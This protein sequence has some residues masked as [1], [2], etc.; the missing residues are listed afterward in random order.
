MNQL[1]LLSPLWLLLAAS[2]GYLIGR[3]RSGL[4]PYPVAA[5][6]VLLCIGFLGLSGQPEQLP[7]SYAAS[8]AHSFG[9]EYR[10]RIDGLALTFAVLITGI[11]ALVFLYAASYMKEK[12]ETGGFFLTLAVFTAAMLGLVL[13]DN[14]L[15]TFLFWELTSLC[16]FLLISFHFRKPEVAASA[17]KAL[18]VTF[19]G[20]LVLL[21]GVILISIAGVR[22]GATLV[23][24]LT[25]SLIS[26]E[27][28]TGPLYPWI[29]ACIAV[30]VA[31]KSAQFPFH[32]WLPAAMAGPTPVSSFLHSATMVKA[33]VFL[34]AR[35][36]PV[37]GGT[38]LWSIVFCS[39]GVTTMLLGALLAASF[40]D[41]KKI[42]AFST[43]AVL[44]I[45][46]MLLGIGTPMAVKAAVVFLVAHALYKASLFQI[47]GNLDKA[48][49]SRDIKELS[50]LGR[51]LPLTAVAALLSSFSKAGSPPL[52]GFFGKELAYAAKLELGWS[53][54]IMM[55]AAVFANV[56][57]VGLAVSIAFRPFWKG[58]FAKTSSPKDIQKLP[59]VMT[60]C[61][62]LLGF[63]GLA[64]GVFPAMFDRTLGSMMVSAVLGTQTEMKLK[65][66]HGFNP[67]SLIVIGLSAVTL[68]AGVAV[69]FKLRPVIIKGEALRERLRFGPD[70][71]YDW[72]MQSIASGANRLTAWLQSGDLVS[73]C[74]WV[75]LS[76]FGLIALALFSGRLGGKWPD[77]QWTE[78]VT[79][80]TLIAL[81][82]M[83]ALAS[84]RLQK[85][86]VAGAV[87]FVLAVVFV[88]FSA[89][90]LALTQI[91]VEA[92]SIA[93]FLFYLFNKAVRTLPLQ[94]AAPRPV[95][96]GIAI[97]SGT[98]LAAALIPSVSR[99]SRDAAA[100]FTDNALT[101][102]FGR[103]V[104]NVI[105][106]DFR[107]IDTF[108]EVLVI[109]VTGVAVVALLGIGRG[110]GTQT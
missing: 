1:L 91:S 33:G 80:T 12:Q 95:D 18:F 79:A 31:T 32:F 48:T 35:L 34:L 103:N 96:I 46:V 44:G 84:D 106:V 70:R 28:L 23:D 61:P 49:G 39:L 65:L 36:F 66:W 56:L 64:V 19:G 43:I 17:R 55:A 107:A 110:R 11:G 30:G 81:A 13:S 15:L 8:W 92:L 52:F 87:G 93:F 69:A 78:I 74:R 105:L 41:I 38:P 24:S 2:V 76:G 108:G 88:I 89:P 40:R 62:L 14:L 72:A 57:L 5:L 68:A 58:F 27:A 7:A 10:M 54:L 4:G 86:I 26:R 102:A 77:M 53:G 109:A 71:I 45:L 83:L 22:N 47:V 94:V 25:I 82:V 90:D 51:I 60:L 9:L 50:G 104:V 99:F 98:V 59:L 29:L 21:L 85:L 37:L 73:Y 16:S 100:Y 75:L 6:L 42:L 3:V 97:L 63:A 101:S 20:G 67:E